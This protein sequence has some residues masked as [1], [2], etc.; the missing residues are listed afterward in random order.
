MLVSR[1]S[2]YINIVAL[3]FS[4]LLSKKHLQ[5]NL[6]QIYFLAED[7]ALMKFIE[8]WQEMRDLESFKLLVLI[9]FGL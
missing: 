3:H 4:L 9:I 6:T 1:R 8:I 2:Y 5:R 7:S